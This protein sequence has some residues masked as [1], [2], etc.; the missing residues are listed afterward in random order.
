MSDKIKDLSRLIEKKGIRITPQ[1]KDII[2]I[3]I[4]NKQN[5]LSAS[6]IYNI[7][8]KQNKSSGL[9]TIYR[10]L[11]ILEKANIVVKRDFDSNTSYYEFIYDQTKHNH[12][13][14]KKCGKVIEIPDLL[15]DDI[16]D[17]IL[18]EKGFKCLHY[19]TKFYGYCSE[20]LKEK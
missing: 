3:F 10:T 1:R 16:K 17:K 5:H 8:K 18:E 12:L 14:C 19:S 9:A 20:C 7:L 11:D 15:P 6:D 2:K 13:I 4:D